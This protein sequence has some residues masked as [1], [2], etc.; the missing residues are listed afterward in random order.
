MANLTGLYWRRIAPQVRQR[1]RERLHD[2]PQL[3]HTRLSVPYV[4]GIGA[5]CFL[6]PYVLWWLTATSRGPAPPRTPDGVEVHQVLT[7]LHTVLAEPA[8]GRLPNGSPVPF[9]MR[10]VE[11]E[12]HFVVQK[13]TPSR[14]S[15]LYR[16]V[17]ADTAVQVRPEHVQI[18]KMRLFP[19]P[20]LPS[21][22]GVSVSSTAASRA[23]EEAGL[24]KPAL[25][26][27]RDRP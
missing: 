13:S 3:L 15:S 6:L 16:L 24:R 23:A 19:T 2:T 14:D 4:A 8:L 10:D 17:P 25:P 20:P 12:L 22:L 7:A 1:L 9:A 18:L 5:V 26:K 27:K 21:Q 11:V